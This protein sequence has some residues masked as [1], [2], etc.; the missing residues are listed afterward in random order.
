L[1]ASIVTLLALAGAAF[2]GTGAAG[3]PAAAPDRAP[4]GLCRPDGEI[5]STG[6]SC[7]GPLTETRMLPLC[8]S[9]VVTL[10]CPD[11]GNDGVLVCGSP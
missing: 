3:A 1:A 2:A 9:R 4:A 11:A 6:N 10:S 8:C 7:P 5:I